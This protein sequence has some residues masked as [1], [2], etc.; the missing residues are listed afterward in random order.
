[1]KTRIIINLPTKISGNENQL[2]RTAPN[3]NNQEWDFN[4]QRE[5]WELKFHSLDYPNYPRYIFNFPKYHHSN[6]ENKLK[7]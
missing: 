1:M 6:K 2:H 3:I 5:G 4:S 7:K